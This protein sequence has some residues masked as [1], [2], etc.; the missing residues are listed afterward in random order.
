MWVLKSLSDIVSSSKIRFSPFK[1]KHLE[2]GVCINISY[3]EDNN[4]YWNTCI[5]TSL[6]L[7]CREGH[8][9][10]KIRSVTVTI[11]C[12]VGPYTTV[13]ATLRLLSHQYRIS[14]VATSPNDYPQSGA[15]DKRFATANIPITASAVSSGPNDSGVFELNF[16]DERYMPFE[17][18][19][20]ISTWQLNLPTTMQQFDYDSI[21]DVVVQIRYTSVDDGQA[22]GGP[23]SGAVANSLKTVQDASSKLGLCSIFDLK[24]EFSSE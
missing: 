3:H 17:I 24:N 10:R 2:K 9:L 7:L 16:R 11:P 19:G 4:L 12:V 20:A 8:Y 15:D 13:N 22:L 1:S 21:T 14:S 5:S 18:A 6:E 23:A